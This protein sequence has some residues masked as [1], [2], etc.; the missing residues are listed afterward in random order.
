MPVFLKVVYKRASIEDYRNGGQNSKKLNFP[1]T[2]VT[3]SG[4]GK[5]D[6]ARL[7]AAHTPLRLGIKLSICRAHTAPESRVMV[8]V[9]SGRLRPSRRPVQGPSQITVTGVAFAPQTVCGAGTHGGQGGHTPGRGTGTSSLPPAQGAE[10]M[11]EVDR[12]FFAR[13][14]FLFASPNRARSLQL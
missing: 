9:P 13:P 5:V 7:L 8:R 3:C 11:L 1:F 12:L 10:D 2:R 14:R 6:H 4:V